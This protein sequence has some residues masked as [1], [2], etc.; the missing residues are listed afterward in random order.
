VAVTKLEQY[1][2]HE[3]LLDPRRGVISEV[4]GADGAEWPGI[5]VLGKEANLR[6][7][8]GPVLRTVVECPADSGRCVHNEA[9]CLPAI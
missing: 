2:G 1:R 8:G 4:W 6:G 9:E 7:R 3:G 5:V